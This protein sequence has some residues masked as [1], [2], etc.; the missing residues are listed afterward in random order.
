MNSTSDVPT[1]PALMTNSFSGIGIGIKAGTKTVTIPYRLNHSR[2]FAPFPSGAA[3]FMKRRPPR[4]ALEKRITLP[5]V[6]PATASDA[7]NHATDGRSTAIRTRS[8]SK[9]PATGTPE[10]SRM[11]RSRMPAGPQAT[12]ASVKW[13]SKFNV[14]ATRGQRLGENGFMANTRTLR[15]VTVGRVAVGANSWGAAAIGALAV[16]AFAAGALAIGSLAIG[17]LA[18][19]K[20]RLK[21][22]SIDDLK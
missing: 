13:R 8:A 12:R 2:N 22:V 3:L 1:T 11:D 19:G 16:G 17:R 10:E 6:D 7:H 9:T 14:N 21:S 15:Y 5:M 4:C 18:V 20:A